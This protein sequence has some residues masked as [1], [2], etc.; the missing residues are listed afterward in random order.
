MRSG[1]KNLCIGILTVLFIYH[2]MKHAKLI[3]LS[4]STNQKEF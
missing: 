3:K 2:M 4:W 1:D